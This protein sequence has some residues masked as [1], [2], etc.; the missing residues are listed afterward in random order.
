[1][2]INRWLSRFIHIS[3]P[4]ASMLHILIK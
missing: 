2:A 3:F 1:M 4:V